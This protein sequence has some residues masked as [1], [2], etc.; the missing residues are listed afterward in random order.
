MRRIVVPVSGGKDSQACLKMA[1]ETHGAENVEGLFC[2]TQ[3]EHP[4]TYAHIEWMRLLYGVTI[5]VITAGSVG[6]K[7][8]KHKRFPDWN[9]RHCTDELKLR[10][11]RD[12]LRMYALF[13]G[14]VEVWYGMRSDESS[15]RASR[16]AGKN[17]TDLYPPHEVLKKKYPK[18]LGAMG[19]RFRLAVLHWTDDDVFDYLA[20][21]ENP[22]Y[23]EGFDR[24]GCFPCLAA[25]KRAKDKA[26][27]HD[28]FGRAQRKVVWLMEQDTGKSVY[29]GSP[30][31]YEGCETCAT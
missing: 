11:T 24:V 1:V 10:P 29:D 14:A 15:Q 3:F 20:G 18:Y 26:F 30:P 22:L 6:D 2:D 12:W 13:N 4:K 19:V 7:V 8:R 28:D 31:C 23:D 9:S 16:Y 25:G 5:H 17:S 21:M 27:Q